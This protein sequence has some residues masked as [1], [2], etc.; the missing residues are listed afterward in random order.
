MEASR[1]KVRHHYRHEV[2]LSVE[3]F[4]RYERSR[5][6][7]MTYDIERYLKLPSKVKTP[8][9]NAASD[10]LRI[11]KLFP[12]TG[13]NSFSYLPGF[14]LWTVFTRESSFDMSFLRKVRL[15]K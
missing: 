8:T 7:G 1:C 11:V 4:L 10:M 15:L 13:G 6:E 12:S 14:G 5:P 2:P 3:G 9:V